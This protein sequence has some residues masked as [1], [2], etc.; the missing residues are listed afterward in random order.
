MKQIEVSRDTRKMV[1]WTDEH[2]LLK[3]GNSIRFKDHPDWWKIEEVFNV[4]L[5]KKE[6]KRDWHVGGL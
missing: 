6:I 3:K 2:S 5:A 1:T 4:S